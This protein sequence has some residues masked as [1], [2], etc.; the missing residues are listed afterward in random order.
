MACALQAKVSEAMG[1]DIHPAAVIGRGLLLDHGMGVVIGETARI[2]NNVSMMQ[3][4]TLGGALP[5]RPATSLAAWN[6]ALLISIVLLAA[7][8]L[9]LPDKVE[10]S[11]SCQHAMYYAI[12]AVV[13]I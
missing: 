7:L 5:A 9:L 2:G 13:Y 12:F 11:L 10:G 8:I 1:I 6:Y 4:V 3:N